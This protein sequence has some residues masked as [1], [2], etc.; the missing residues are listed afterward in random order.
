MSYKINEKLAPK[1][2][3]DFK[4]WHKLACH[5]DPLTAEERYVEIGG[6]LPAKDVK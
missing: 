2:W 3:S 1:K 6:K 5:T 4:K